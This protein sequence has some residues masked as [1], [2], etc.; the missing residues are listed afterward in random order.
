M[1]PVHLSILVALV[2]LASPAF[3][4]APSLPKPGSVFLEEL[5]WIEVRDAIAPARQRSS[6]P[7]AAPSRTGRTSSSENTITW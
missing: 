6:F 5:T 4:Q 3:T 2:G 7:P 1:K